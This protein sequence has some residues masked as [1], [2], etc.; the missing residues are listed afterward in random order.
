MI[1]TETLGW[2]AGASTEGVSVTR[3]RTYKANATKYPV[4]LLHGRGGD[5]T[6]SLPKDLIAFPP[7]T[8]LVANGYCVFAIDGGGPINGPVNWGNDVS[9]AC[10]TDVITYAVA[11][12]GAK[13]GG[14]L[15]MAISMGTLSGLS[16]AARNPTVAKAM[17]SLFPAVDLADM[18][19]QAAFTAEIDAAYTNNAGY[20][21]ALA[22]HSPLLQATSLR[23]LDHKLYTSTN[24][25]VTTPA[26][27]AAYIEAVPNA[28]VQSLGA[29]GHGNYALM[30]GP[31]A[32]Q[33]LMSRN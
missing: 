5:H 15:L 16:Y 26:T 6:T 24:D 9:I 2:R 33:F 29:V 17:V 1:V 19:G 4:V 14:V 27:V 12:Y 10:I 21:A 13:A 23:T 20:L 31:D 32:A 28:K 25:T 22:T 18:H 8:E 3:D 11:N 7:T 30:P